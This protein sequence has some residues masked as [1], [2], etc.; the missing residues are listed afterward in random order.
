MKALVIDDAK[1]MRM[2]LRQVLTSLGFVV[3]EA[4]SG[5]EGL[6]QLRQSPDVDLVLVDFH[7]SDM[8]GI[9]FVRQ[10]RS[11]PAISQVRLLLVTGESE[12]AKINLALAAGANGYLQK[13]FGQQVAFEKIRELGFV[14][15][16]V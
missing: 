2:I 8:N 9:E 10:V 5:R 3:D 16:G 11:E 7:M 4:S 1:T 6:N 13:P 15:S 12:P 14:L